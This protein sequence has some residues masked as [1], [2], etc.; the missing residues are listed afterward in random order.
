M[1]VLVVDENKASH[2]VLCII[3]NSFSFDAVVAKN[4]QEA[5][6]MLQEYDTENPF[7]LVIT[8]WKLPDIN[9]FELAKMIKQ[10]LPCNI[11]QKSSS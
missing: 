7:R 2:I 10:T 9:G 1:R 4:G 8:D 11:R 6:S 3:L 5:L